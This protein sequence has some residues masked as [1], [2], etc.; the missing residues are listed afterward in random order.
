MSYLRESCGLTSWNGESNKSVYE[1]YGMGERANDVDCGV[2]ERAKLNTLK[3]FWACG[4]N[5][6]QLVHKESVHE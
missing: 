3:W 6:R 1:R 5:G 2:T 4:E